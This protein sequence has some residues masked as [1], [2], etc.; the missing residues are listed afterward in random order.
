[1]YSHDRLSAEN[2]DT[3]TI[4]A[5][6]EGIGYEQDMLRGHLLSD[7]RSAGVTGLTQDSLNPSLADAAEQ[8]NKR[9]RDNAIDCPA[10]A[11]V[12][13]DGGVALIEE[14]E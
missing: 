4:K 11:H 3:S 9:I 8:L 14:L 6:T 7:K 2:V 5:G 1:M 13:G 12:V 10:S